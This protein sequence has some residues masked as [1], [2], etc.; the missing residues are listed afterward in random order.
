MLMNARTRRYFG[1][2][3]TNTRIFRFYSFSFPMKSL[4]DLRT[5]ESP[6]WSRV[7]RVASLP[8]TPVVV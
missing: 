1:V 5:L 8:T 7:R 6:A 3:L 2:R 4:W